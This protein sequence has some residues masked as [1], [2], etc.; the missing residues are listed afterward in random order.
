MYPD[1][2]AAT[3]VSRLNQATPYL[4]PGESQT[5]FLGTLYTPSNAAWQR[6]VFLDYNPVVLGGDTEIPGLLM[7]NPSTFRGK[8]V[9]NAPPHSISLHTV[10]VDKIQLETGEKVDGT[11]I[12]IEPILD[13]ISD[14]I[15]GGS[16]TITPVGKQSVTTS[17]HTDDNSYHQN[18]GDGTVSCR[19]HYQVTK[20]ASKSGKV[21]VNSEQDADTNGQEQAN[22]QQAAAKRTV[23]LRRNAA[24]EAALALEHSPHSVPL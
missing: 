9:M 6:F 21:T 7:A 1:S 16:W 24:I 19:I 13:G 20:S 15:D 5:V 10:N 14:D 2:M 3:I 4:G 22:Q 11:S 8:P 23:K 18:G 17:G 12:D